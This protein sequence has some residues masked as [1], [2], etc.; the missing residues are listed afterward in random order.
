MIAPQAGI[1][2]RWTSGIPT[3]SGAAEARATRRRHASASSSPPPRQ[4]P[5]MTAR[6]GTAQAGQT[7]EDR[8]PAAQKCFDSRA[9]RHDEDRLRGRPRAEAGRLGAADHEAAIADVGLDF[10][11]A[12]SP[13]RRGRVDRGRFAID[14]ADR[15]RG[16]RCRERRGPSARSIP[17]SAGK[18][19]PSPR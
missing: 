11:Q 6:V 1:K 14:R 5:W 17:R 18:T 16:C 19:W 15:T 7:I 13:A 4:A 9:V 3:W 12:S 8:Q 10:D 2:P